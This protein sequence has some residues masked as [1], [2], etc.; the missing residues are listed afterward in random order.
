MTGSTPPETGDSSGGTAS[1]SIVLALAGAALA[2]AAAVAARLRRQA[3]DS[4]A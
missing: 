3:R 2:L 1:G 4:S